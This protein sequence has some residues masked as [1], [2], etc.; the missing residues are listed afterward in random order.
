MRS[1]TQAQPGRARA[2][3]SPPRGLATSVLSTL[4][5]MNR[6]GGNWLT[7]LP[8]ACW[9]LGDWRKPHPHSPVAVAPGKP[10][11]LGEE[12]E[13]SALSVPGS[14]ARVRRGQAPVMWSFR[15]GEGLEEMTRQEAHPKGNGGCTL[16]IPGDIRRTTG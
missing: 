16:A 8:W 13:G 3:P 10:S 6:L 15:T 2:C 5:C 14:G 11:V 12:R 7:Y 1:G 9:G 4:S